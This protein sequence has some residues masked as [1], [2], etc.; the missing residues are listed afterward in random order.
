L[1]ETVL[2]RRYATALF[3][4]ALER[5]MLGKVREELH[6]FAALLKKD[7]KLRNFLFSPEHS[8]AEQKKA[9]E[10]SFADRFSELF[11]NFLQ[12]LIEKRRQTLIQEIISAFEALHD[13][14]LR[15]MRAL[16]ITAVPM[17]QKALEQLRTSLSKSLDMDMELQNR[18]DPEILG[19]LV[20]QVEG[21]ILDGSIRQHLLR[22]R[23]RI[24]NSRN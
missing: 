18:V 2:A 16:A 3:E 24:M 20:V 23:Q 21:K 19:G 15:K 7:S 14:H 4:S 1:K 9:V 13:R 22:M 12:V 17:D 6:A 11:F 8:R 5:K 10:K